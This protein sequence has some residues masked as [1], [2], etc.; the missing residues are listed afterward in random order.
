M[1]RRL[2]HLVIL[3]LSVTAKTSSKT[4]Y[5]PLDALEEI[6]FFAYKEA[7]SKNM[8]TYGDNKALHRHDVILLV[9]LFD[10]LRK[11]AVWR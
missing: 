11:I 9:N 4:Y 7:L 1:L 2:S 5:K 8:T 3:F 6:Y 10:F